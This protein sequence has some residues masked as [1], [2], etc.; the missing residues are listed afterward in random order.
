MAPQNA[1]KNPES[2]SQTRLSINDPQRRQQIRSHVVTQTLQTV[3]RHVQ[4]TKK[5]L[6]YS[7]VDVLYTQS[8]FKG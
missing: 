3:K 6:I 8:F 4:L 2:E 1:H 7:L 5:D